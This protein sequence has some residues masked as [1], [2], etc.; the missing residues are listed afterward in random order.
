MPGLS[1]RRDGVGQVVHLRA[2][3]QSA[4]VAVGRG[5]LW[6]A[7][8]LASCP[9]IW[10]GYLLMAAYD[11]N[12]AVTGHIRGTARI[13]VTRFSNNPQ[14]LQNPATYAPKSPGPQPCLRTLIAY[15]LVR[16]TLPLSCIGSAPCPPLFAN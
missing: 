5:T 3:C 16:R 11:P 15:N 6:V 13:L 9:T 8:S 10:R 2:D 14:S 7:R 1:P 4:P 12:S